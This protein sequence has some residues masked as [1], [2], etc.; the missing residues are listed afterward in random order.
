MSASSSA[1]ASGRDPVPTH[2]PTLKARMCVFIIMQKG[3]T[4]FYVISV[5]EEDIVQICMTLG[6][7]HPLGVLRYSAT[8]LVALFCMAEEMQL[9]SHGAIKA[10]EVCNESIA[11]KT[12][13]PVE[14]HIRAYIIVGGLPCEPW[15]PSSEGENDTNLPTGNPHWGGGTPQYLQAELG[16]LADQQL[17]QLL[18][19]PHQEIALHKVHESPSNLQPNP[20]G[21]PSG[22]GNFDGDDQEVTFPR[23]EGVFP[24]TAIS[25]SS[26]SMTRWR[27][28][29]LG[30]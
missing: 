5:T 20:W 23:G 1:T 27:M 8:E 21:E 26:S 10:M 12:V 14:S 11:I 16:D 19:D 24:K 4:L 6:H 13:A 28:G 22:S 25:D 18:E 2:D 30:T 9:A 3:G 15:S 7:I 17:W 29:S